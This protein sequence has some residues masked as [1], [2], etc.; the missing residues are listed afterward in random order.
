MEVFEK[1]PLASPGSANYNGIKLNDF[2]TSFTEIT[3]LL[4]LGNTIFR[5]HVLLNI[6]DFIST[7]CDPPLPLTTFMEKK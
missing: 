2:R 4:G 3:S 5:R 7:F 1:Q 6:K